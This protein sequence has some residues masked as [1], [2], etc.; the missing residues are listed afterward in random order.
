[1]SLPVFL[2]DAPIPSDGTQIELTGPEARH[3]VTVTRLRVGERIMLVDGRGTTAEVLVTA[4]SG[5][6]RLV[7][8]VEKRTKVPQP[9]PQAIVVQALPK[10]ERSELA[11]DLATQAGA[12]VIVPWQASRCVA[13][14]QGAKREKG[15]AKWRAMAVSAA[16]Q[17]RRS[18]IPE[19]RDVQDTAGIAALIREI[20]AGGGL[21]LLLHE[22][23]TVSF[24][25]ID[26]STCPQV[27]VVGPE[28]GLAPDEVA[29]FTHAGARAVLLGPEVLRT[30]SAAMVALAALGVCSGRW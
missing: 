10:S 24:S 25:S 22:D 18:W 26:F 14:W 5:K 15:V 20:V 29:E 17:S 8:D 19:V 30:A 4:V 11:V 13:K 28:G 9:T 12:D 7:G 27:F 6:D 3:A 21:A 1:M 2:F 16:K 23:A